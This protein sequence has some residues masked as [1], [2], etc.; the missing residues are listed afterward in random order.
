MIINQEKLDS[1]LA[2]FQ[3][4]YAEATPFPNTFIDDFLTKPYLEVITKDFPSVNDKTWTHYIHYNERK[5]G[6]TKWEH[7]PASVKDLITEMSQPAFLG[8]LEKLTG[9]QHLFA[10]PALEG[11]GLHQTL[12]GGFLNI[13][14]DFTAHPLHQNWQRRVNVLIYLNEDW[15]PD[16]GGELELWDGDMQNCIQRISPIQNRVAIFNTGTKTYHGYPTPVSCPDGVSRKS[17]AM[18]FYTKDQ[19]FK[20]VTT[21]YRGRPTDG[22]KKALIWADTKALWTYSKIK[23]LLGLNDD[24]IS[25]ILSKFN[26]KK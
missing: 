25:S 13:H 19:K 10:D 18:Y 14:A 20:K 5:H 22:Y 17:I 9:I 8:W 4:A 3:K 16:W 1:Q 23:G 6:L 15:N 21:D 26:A 12:S 2:H 7:F 11:S 24:F